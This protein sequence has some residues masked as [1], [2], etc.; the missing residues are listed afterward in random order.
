MT[1]SGTWLLRRYPAPVFGILN[2]LVRPE[3]RRFPTDDRSGGLIKVGSHWVE[4]REIFAR[5]LSDELAG[6]TINGSAQA[7]KINAESVRN[8]RRRI[9]VRLEELSRQD[10]PF[11]RWPEFLEWIAGSWPRFDAA[12]TR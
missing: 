8:I 9:L 7:R 1:S 6:L 12:H 4:K 10:L 5:I 2:Q 3:R 11:Q